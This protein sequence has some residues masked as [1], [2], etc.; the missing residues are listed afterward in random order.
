MSS[1]SQTKL[2]SQYHLGQIHLEHR[3]VMPPLTRLRSNP[4][5]SPSDMMVTHYGQRASKGGL[6][7]IEAATVSKKGI[8]YQGMPGIYEDRHIAGFERIADAIHAKGGFAFAQIIH[9]GRTSHVDLQPNGESPLAPSATSYHG[10]AFLNGEF[11]PVSPARE[12]T[13]AEILEVVE[14]FR[15]AALRARLAGL[16]GVEI[17][18]ANGYLLD[19]FLQDGSNHRTDAYGGSI[20]NRARFLLEV[21]KAVVSVW[22]PG[23]VGVRIGP[24]GTFNEMSDSNPEALFGY[25]AEQ[26]N[27]LDL[28]YLHVIEP[29]VAGDVTRENA[30][31]DE[32]VASKFLR[33]I[34]KGTLLAAGGFNRESAE[35]ILRSGD[36]DL[37]AIG[38]LFTSNPDLPERLKNG[39]PLNDY[40]RSAFWGGTERSY[41]DFLP[42]QAEAAVTEAELVTV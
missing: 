11:V 37:V 38:R 26:L 13:V 23:R 5:D 25:V 18:S 22:G 20:E 21:A 14:D 6:I 42:Y 39:Y 15:Q 27:G 4:D 33:G 7:I 10:H 16:D 2:F 1:Q 36:A 34:Y 8:G 17:H 3:L 9:T 41:T 12:I 35:E 30:E 29:R 28:A 19:Q 32:V 40:D 31:A 24:S